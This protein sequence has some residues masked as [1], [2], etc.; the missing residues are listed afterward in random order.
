MRGLAD[1]EHVR[2]QYGDAS[3]LDARVA[4]YERF[5]ESRESWAEWLL[6]RLALAPGERVLDAGAGSG[7]LWRECGERV[8]RGVRVHAVCPGPIRTEWLTRDL[9]GR[10]SEQSAR[11]KLSAGSDPE[12]VARAVEKC[13]TARASRTVAV[14]RWWGIARLGSNAAISRVLDVVVAPASSAIVR[15]ARRYGE[16]L[17]SSS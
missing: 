11:A 16:R 2:E 13:L 6:A 7:R 15:V 8:P 17:G 9:T 4:I 3:R 12:H 5:S 10:P 14:P 1:P